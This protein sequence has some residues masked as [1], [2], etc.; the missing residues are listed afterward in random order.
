MTFTAKDIR[1]YQTEVKNNTP[2]FIREHRAAFD[3]IIDTIIKQIQHTV[4]KNP[5]AHRCTI[6]I[7]PLIKSADGIDPVTDSGRFRMALI[8]ELESLGFTAVITNDPKTLNY[9]MDVSWDENEATH[10]ND[11]SERLD[12]ID[13]AIASLAKNLDIAGSETRISTKLD[14]VN[15]NVDAV[16]S[17]VKDN[18]Y[19]IRGLD[20]Y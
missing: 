3:N 15:K 6:D 10:Q 14:K 12:K 13:A 11:I 20:C 5:E 8:S 4:Y 16:K 9:L 18:Y 7:T 17:E 1:A 2:R 19:A